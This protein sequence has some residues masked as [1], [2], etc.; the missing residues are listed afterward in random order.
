[1]W[2]W[3]CLPWIVAW[4][5]W[6]DNV[7]S[8]FFHLLSYV[9][10][11][12]SITGRTHSHRHTHIRTHTHRW[13]LPLPTNFTSDL[14]PEDVSWCDWLPL[15]PQVGTY[16]WAFFPNPHISANTAQHAYNH[17]LASHPYISFVEWFV[18]SVPLNGMCLFSAFSA[19]LDVNA[20]LKKYNNNKKTCF[21]T[22][23]GE[24]L[25]WAQH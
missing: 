2:D 22:V 12:L 3:S 9:S 16:H 24:G 5:W 1:M 21:Q 6:K 25:G 10:P 14:F 4:S 11:S 15:A 8:T 7:T 19:N 18:S 23:E 17:V 13:L 20:T